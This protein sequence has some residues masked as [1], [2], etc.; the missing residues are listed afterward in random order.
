[1]AISKKTKRHI[2]K[3]LSK[4]QKKASLKRKHTT[5]RVLVTGS[6]GLIGSEAVRFFCEK[7]FEVIGVDNDM[8]AYF[9]GKDASTDWNRK[10]L[11]EKYKNY[12]HLN[13]DVRDADE[14]E[15]IF[16]KYKFGLIIHTAAQPSHDWAARE[17]VT[18]FSINALGTMILLEATRKYCPDAVFIFTSTNK[19][20]GDTPNTLPLIELETRWELP[21]EHKF[22]NGID[23][24]MSI[25]TSLHSLF[26]ASKAAADILAQEYGRYFGIKTGIFR[27]GC[28][29]GPAHSG[30]Q[31]H[32]FLAY[33][34]KAIASQIPYTIFGYK[35]K[36]VRDN[37]HAKDLVSAFYHFYKKPRPGEVYNMGGNRHSHTSILEVIPKIEKILKK[38]A[39]FSYHPKNR[40]GDHIWYVSDISK[41]KN[42]YPD[43]KYQYNEDLILEELCFFAKSHQ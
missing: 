1:M 43:W 31:L 21:K 8:R 20:Y 2:P 22:Y 27:G 35:G 36:Q 30:A 23:E 34:V 19:V 38:K 7:G 4:R 5:R 42:H 33:L 14:I 41:F 9:F 37:I 6:A 26:G 28:I 15:K 12:K 39:N 16:K 11:E 40:I 29:T 24:S 18:D 3:R 10:R 13:V 25:D 17:P 32:G